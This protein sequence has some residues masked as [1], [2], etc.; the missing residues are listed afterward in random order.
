VAA[1]ESP[2]NSQRFG[3]CKSF[4]TSILLHPSKSSVLSATLCRRPKS[5]Q[6]LNITQDSDC[7]QNPAEWDC[8]TSGNNSI[9]KAKETLP[10]RSNG[11]IDFFQMV[12]RNASQSNRFLNPIASPQSINS[13]PD[14][15]RELTYARG[16]SIM[17]VTMKL[18]ENVKAYF[19][20]QG[21]I[22]AAKRK[23]L[24][25][26]ERRSEIARTAA[27]ARWA[28]L[29]EHTPKEKATK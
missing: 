16:L 6:G 19:R 4:R 12:T 22:G 20:R 3:A 18:P 1:A 27:Q 29:T 26:P 10:G 8:K 13:L 23:E 11:T 25:T 7:T 21:K 14:S 15:F 9:S 24:L 5:A 17:I 28:K 2:Q